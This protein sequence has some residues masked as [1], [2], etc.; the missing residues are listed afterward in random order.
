MISLY[1]WKEII[2]NWTLYWW[3]IDGIGLLIWARVAGIPA[4]S[5]LGLLQIILGLGAVVTN[6]FGGLLL[7][8]L[9]IILFPVFILLMVIRHKIPTMQ[10]K[11]EW[12]QIWE[13]SGEP[14]IWNNGWFVVGIA[15]VIV[16]AFL[17]EIIMGDN[18]TQLEHTLWN[19]SVAL[20]VA[21]IS[22]PGAY[23]LSANCLTRW[24]VR[25]AT[26]ASIIGAIGLLIASALTRFL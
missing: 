1:A 2:I 4:F 3:I 9:S 26:I 6:I 24:L 17:A 19:C 11:C 5:G 16:L 13:S 20:Y 15:P 25:L 18:L 8:F 22:P 7:S 12:D 23:G 21:A 10:N 14:L